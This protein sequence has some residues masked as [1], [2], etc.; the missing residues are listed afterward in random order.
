MNFLIPQIFAE[1]KHFIIA[2]KPPKMHSV[3]L[4]KFPEGE[5]G[6]T[7]IPEKDSGKT[8][9]D[10][11]VEQFPEILDLPGRNKGEGGLLHRLDYETHGLM[12]AARTLTGMKSLMEQQQNR[13]IIKE[14]SAIS[15]PAKS[16][17]N[18]F[19]AEKP[20]FQ[21][22]EGL[23]PVKISSAFRP[24]GKG[25]KAIRPVPVNYAGKYRNKEIVFDGCEP[26]VTEITDIGSE[27][28]IN[29]LR[30]RIYKGFRHQIRCHLAWFGI[31]I[32]NDG[33]YGGE[34]FGKN[35]LA[36]RS[37]SISFNDPISGKNR[38]FSIN[39]VNLDDLL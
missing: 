16:V 9:L 18:G 33:L 22:D 12:L 29:Y 4:K 2:Y 37:I 30:I 26:Y 35:I 20:Q 11:C 19:P 5:S 7:Q 13:G 24:F 32:L 8:M 27:P 34:P 15:S 1:D 36:L 23:Y 39:P 28:G 17:L 31:P 3:P 38:S 6:P 14:Y 21:F 25:R 10:Y